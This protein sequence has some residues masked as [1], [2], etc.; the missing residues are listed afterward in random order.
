MDGGLTATRWDDKDD[1][2]IC[3]GIPFVDT[4]L[5]S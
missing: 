4:I 3:P 1:D 2:R 5:L